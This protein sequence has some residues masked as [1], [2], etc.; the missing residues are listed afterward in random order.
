MRLHRE[1]TGR[2]VLNTRVEGTDLQVRRVEGNF[3]DGV[4]YFQI[5]SLVHFS[6]S[7][8]EGGRLKEKPYRK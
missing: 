5:L 3:C 4:L 8:R 6:R 1:G 7:T 2:F